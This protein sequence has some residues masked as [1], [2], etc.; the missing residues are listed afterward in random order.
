MPRT[1][2]LQN[3][4]SNQQNVNN[5]TNTTATTAAADNNNNNNNNSNTNNR[6]Q[7]LGNLLQTELREAAQGYLSRT[8]RMYPIHYVFDMSDIEF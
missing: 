6:E 3:G 8:R 2:P 5:N 1:V 4:S 7:L